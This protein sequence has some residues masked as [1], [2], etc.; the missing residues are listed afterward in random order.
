MFSKCELDLDGLLTTVESESPGIDCC[1]WG[2]KLYIRPM[3]GI[4]GLYLIK[5][6][7]HVLC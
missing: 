5:R 6:P 2:D 1:V 4:R 3:E 7:Y